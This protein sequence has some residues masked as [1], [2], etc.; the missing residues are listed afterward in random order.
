M[1]PDPTLFHRRSNPVASFFAAAAALAVGFGFAAA[2]PLDDGKTVLCFVSHKTSHGFGAHEYAPGCRLIGQWLADTYPAAKVESRYSIGWPEKPEEF[3]RDADTVV[4]FCSGGG[5]HLV[6]GHVPELDK[7]MRTGAGLACLHYAVEVPIGPSAK[8]M[9]A[10]MGGYFEM[11]W[12]VN[13]HWK[14]EF[15]VFPDHPAARG[16]KPFVIDD[17][18]YFHM[19]F[20]EGLKG[21]TPILS[22]VAP[23]STMSRPDGPH[24]GN[25]AVRAAVAK[26]EPQH[27]A[28]AYERGE[29][30]AKG[31]GY[32]FTGLHYHWNWED[33]NFRRAVLNGVAWTA[34]LDIPEGGIETP[35]PTR[36]SLEAN[37]LEHAGD[38]G[39]NQ[40]KQQKASAPK[41][42]PNVKP[43]FESA[44]VTGK[45][46]GRS[47]DVAVDL[48]AGTKEIYL[49]VS[50]GGDGMAFDWSNW[51]EPR[52]VLADGSEKKLTELDW[53]SATAEWGRISRVNNAGGQEMRV[54]GKKLAYGVGTHA[55]SVIHYAIPGGAKKFLAKGALDDGGVNQQG[56]NAP[57]SVK[58]LVFDKAPDG[59]LAQAKTRSAPG[60]GSHDPA[61]AVANLE[62]HPELEA[63]LYASEPMVLSPSAIDVDEKGRVWVCEV[64]NYRRHLGERK[65]GDRILILE[66]SDGD[67]K[68]DKTTVF[69]QGTDIDSAHGICVLGSR[70]IVSAGEEVFSLFDDNGDGKSDR[71]EMMFTKIGGKQHDHGIH[72]VHFGPDGRLYFNFGNAGQRL[73]DK[74]GQEITDINGVKCTTSNNRP[75]QQGLVFRCEPDGSRV[76]MLGWNFRNNWEVAVDSFGTVWQSDNDD[77][78]NQGVRINYVMEYGNYGYTD[79]LTGAGWREPRVGMETEI[80]LRHWRLNDPGV[81]PNLLQTGAGSP[82]GIVVYEGD[83]LPAVFRGQMIHCDAGPSVVRAYPVKKAGAGY[84]AETVNILE[85]TRNRWF[86]PSDVCVAPDGSLVVADWYDPGVGGHAMGDIERGRIFQVIPK[87]Q[88]PKKTPAPAKLDTVESAIAG[89][90]SP[91]ESARYLAW[92][93][94]REMGAKAEPALK[95]LFEDEKADT[96]HRARALWLLTRIDVKH[97]EAAL[98]NADADLRI[99]AF[100][101]IRQAAGDNREPVLAAAETIVADKD[102][103]VRREAALALRHVAG[104]KADALWAQLAGQADVSDRWM[105]EALGIG[106]D[107]HWESRLAAAGKL[108]NRLV[109]R[110]RAPESAAKIV[111]IVLAGSESDVA[112]YLRALDFQ[113]AGET[114]DAAYRRL[115]EMGKAETALYAAA[116]IGADAIA[117]LDGGP[118]RLDALLAPIRGTAEFVTLAERL[119][120]SGFPDELAA[121]V[122]K[123]PDA[124]E[125]VIAAR[126]LLQ[127]NRGALTGYLRDAGDLPRA[128]AL[129][130]SLGRTGERD[131]SGLLAGELK[132]AETPAPLKIEM[133]NALATNGNSGRELLKLAREGQL[134]ETLKPVAALAIARSPDAGLRNEASSVLPLPKAAGAESFPPVAD[135]ARQAGDAA[136]GAD[137]FTK[138]TCATCHRV[139]GQGIDFGPDLTQIGG[140]LSAEGLLEAILF[141]S[142]AISH[143]FH[144]LSVTKKD[145]STLI[146]FATGET[147]A[148][149][150]LRLPGGVDQSVAKADIAKREDLPQSLM[151]P[152]LAAV[153]GQQ[154][155]VDLVAWLRTLK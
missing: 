133:V 89:L 46:P 135:L 131:I 32:G 15:K 23:D 44:L 94:L 79:E 144:G 84:T 50:D 47:V 61:D 24:S 8:G 62:V 57:S 7:V 87:G 132:R 100:R 71:K 53:K 20:V 40:P 99:T 92:T 109:W 59:Y 154:G 81:V 12:S 38:Q 122:A 66:D 70:V 80:P 155:L 33:D 49:V 98:K 134:D 148:A 41:G 60:G 116:K 149:L 103:Q 125:A 74:D 43:L 91:N 4:F 34:R 29:E 126:L 93:A 101:A 75:H 37:I 28:W 105:V 96:R 86:R 73:C 22:A 51:V 31:R 5:G 1:S 142:A 90:K 119:H 127:A 48:P 83:L 114:R 130:R 106:A 17:E 137:L 26:R 11:N 139:K 117:R 19:R 56:G 72:A 27:V 102:P 152:G 108:P 143:G 14:P 145:G 39:R 112:P 138:A 30:Y 10:W 140:K 65:E 52:F 45:T 68:A 21:V 104:A 25:P 9:L 107:L 3:F 69:H 76:E 111:D 147:D 82:T 128:A 42:D 129:V 35:R 77:D 141:P 63:R 118:A 36:E 110:S 85:G 64:V 88:A 97:A 115:F 95:A 150:Q 58:F 2:G 151:P 67:G 13:P 113:A 18:W 55:T 6:N 136:K 146:G 54:D 153:I 124:P 121:F 16:I 78:G 123:Q 120:L